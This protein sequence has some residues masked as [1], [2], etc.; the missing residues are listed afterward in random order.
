[1]VPTTAGKDADTQ[2]CGWHGHLQSNTPFQ[3][4]L[5]FTCTAYV[6]YMVTSAIFTSHESMSLTGP[7]GFPFI[8]VPVSSCGFLVYRMSSNDGDFS[9]CKQNNLLSQTSTLARRGLQ[10]LQL[11]VNRQIIY[12]LVNALTDEQYTNFKLPRRKSR[13]QFHA[14]F[15][16]MFI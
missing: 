1:M 12:F 5:R 10:W 3:L 15:S 4:H 14:V 11:L 7:W 13:G 2:A 16:Y 6:K 8:C 9:R